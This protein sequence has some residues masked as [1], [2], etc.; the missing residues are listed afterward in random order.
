LNSILIVDDHDD[1]RESLRTVLEATGYSV[2]TACNGKEAL[3]RLNAG[4]LPQLILLD[5][6]M[7][8]MNGWDFRKRQMQDPRFAGIPTVVISGTERDQI[9]NDLDVADFILKP[10]DPIRLLEMVQRYR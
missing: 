3:D 1:L 8:I 2:I 10:I 7:P 4:T 5:L 6:T 9:G